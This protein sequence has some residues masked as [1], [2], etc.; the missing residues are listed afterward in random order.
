MDFASSPVPDPLEEAA[1]RFREFLRTQ[2]WPDQVQWLTAG[3]ALFSKKGHYWIN[4]RKVDEGV[5]YA[6]ETYQ[7]GVKRGLGISIEALCK[8]EAVTFAY[9]F[10]PT[11][12]A[13]A[14]R[15][16][17]SGLKLSVPLNPEPARVVGNVFWWWILRRLKELPIDTFPT[18]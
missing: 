13:E 7:Q 6:R 3:T 9:V 8:T 15:L 11:D 4:S 16:L 17:I 10:V 18:R 12:R 2:G 14:E 1:L 5:A